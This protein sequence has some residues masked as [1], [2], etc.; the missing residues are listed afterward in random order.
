MANEDVKI[1][2]SINASSN[3]IDD[4][5]RQLDQLSSSTEKA[6]QNYEGFVELQNKLNS[7]PPNT[8]ENVLY[9]NHNEQLLGAGIGGNPN[10]NS[11][12]FN[13]NNNPNNEIPST[14]KELA[15]EIRKLIKAIEEERKDSSLTGFDINLEAMLNTATARN[16]TDRGFKID[17]SNGNVRRPD[18]TLL[19]G[20][21]GLEDKDINRFMTMFKM[22]NIGTTLNQLG[23][24]VI[25]QMGQGNLIG[26]GSTVIKGV[27]DTLANMSNQ[28]IVG[29]PFGAASGILNTINAASETYERYIPAIRNARYRSNWQ[30]ENNEIPLTSEGLI[31][32]V[33]ML[34]Q[35]AGLDM[36]TTF[37]MSDILASQG[38]RDGYN[39]R[40]AS[41]RPEGYEVVR[42]PDGTVSRDPN[43]NMSYR[44]WENNSKDTLERATQFAGYY[45]GSDTNL[46][47][48]S[49][50]MASRYG[51]GDVLGFAA[52]VNNNQ[53]GG[54]IGMFDESLRSLGS[55]FENALSKGVNVNNI[56]DLAR[57]QV[58]FGQMGELWQGDRGAQRIAQMSST[59]SSHDMSSMEGQLQ[60]IDFYNNWAERTRGTRLEGTDYDLYNA[61]LLREELA[62]TRPDELARGAQTLIKDLSGDDRYS[63]LTLGRRM[64]G[65]NNTETN[66]IINADLRP[67]T[68]SAVT[69]SARNPEDDGELQNKVNKTATEGT[70]V[71]IGAS[72][73]D[74]KNSIEGAMLETIKKLDSTMTD[75]LTLIKSLS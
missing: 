37:Q 11:N 8:P 25:G 46:I 15:G 70:I 51:S 6:Y 35:E 58:V 55:L 22:A 57:A 72:A 16:L 23:Q 73:M 59:L 65:T 1:N 7:T 3:G 12:P 66:D 33:S 39:Y 38:V 60:N 62:A 21:D 53:N 63:A 56:G 9:Q 54:A 74:A 34:S 13:P 47:A 32:R 19:N 20:Q 17:P 40:T 41:S 18:G 67:S 49:S 69:V 4:A 10:P 28:P 48:S 36:S 64:F 30:K 31:D 68:L 27:G 44:K 43:G 61:S 26:A 52:A 5:T 75:L 24:N 42:N 14:N 50:G 29:V 2:L 71:N 45:V